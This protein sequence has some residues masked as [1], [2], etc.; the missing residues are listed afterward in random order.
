M[1]L[2]RKCD[3]CSEPMQRLEA[4]LKLE[5]DDR[6]MNM[7]TRKPVGWICIRP[8]CHGIMRTWF[9]TPISPPGS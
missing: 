8:G 5:G 2:R 6:P 9:Q 4:R 7:Q 1:T 3:V